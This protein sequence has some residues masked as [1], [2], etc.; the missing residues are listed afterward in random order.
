M[1]SNPTARLNPQRDESIGGDPNELPPEIDAAVIQKAIHRAKMEHFQIGL[2]T[3]LMAF[4]VHICFRRRKSKERCHAYVLGT[5]GKNAVGEDRI[6]SDA[7]LTNRN[8]K[9]VAVTE[10]ADL[11]DDRQTS[12]KNAVQTAAKEAASSRNYDKLLA[13]GDVTKDDVHLVESTDGDNCDELAKQEPESEEGEYEEEKKS[14][15]ALQYL[16]FSSFASGEIKVSS[17]SEVNKEIFI[18]QSNVST[19]GDDSDTLLKREPKS[20]EEGYGEETKSVESLPYLNFSNFLSGNLQESV[21][22]EVN[23]QNNAQPNNNM[24]APFNTSGS[25]NNETPPIHLHTKAQHPGLEAYYH[26]KST[27]MSLYRVYSIP[28]YSYPEITDNNKIQNAVLPMHPSSERGQTAVY[29][30]VTN[31]TSHKVAVYWVDYKGNEIYKGSMRSGATWNQTTYIGHPWTF[32]IETPNVVNDGDER[33]VLLRYVPFRVVPSIQG[34]ET[35]QRD[36]EFPDS[37]VGRHAFALK[38]V[39]EGHGLIVGG[40]KWK[41]ACIVEDLILPEPPLVSLHNEDGRSNGKSVIAAHYILYL[42]LSI[43]L[44]KVLIIISRSSSSES[45]EKLMSE[46]YKELI[47]SYQQIQREEAASLGRGVSAAKI[48]NKYLSNISI[49][50]QEPKFR[51]LRVCNPI[52]MNNIYNTAARGVL[53]ALGFEEHHGYFECGAARGRMLTEDRTAM[54]SDAMAMLFHVSRAFENQK[55]VE[56]FQPVGADGFGRAG[57]GYAGSMNL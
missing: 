53:L 31:M 2:V 37:S 6:K 15:D 54:I 41:P 13:N 21:S 40:E 25:N 26:W 35:V 34:A 14:E 17:S 10:T 39:P 44:L 45:Y 56:M 16:N 8:E 46:I 20:E 7:P 11:S 51:K 18:L 48:L 50:P 29:I 27:I 24:C 12:R 38:N 52:F 4:A 22:S 55:I 47:W 33:S 43:F 23:K 36:H 32:R 1:H 30:E 5:A 49:Y 42:K 9:E 3:T 28:L 57:Y 19:D